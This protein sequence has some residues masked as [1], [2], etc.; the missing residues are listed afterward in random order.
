VPITCLLI[1]DRPARRPAKLVRAFLP[2]SPIS[3]R[4]SSGRH[5]ATA[6]RVIG[7]P[8]VRRPSAASQCCSLAPSVR[9]NVFAG[10]FGSKSAAVH[11][12]P[13]AAGCRVCLCPLSSRE[14]SSVAGPSLPSALAP[15]QRAG[16]PPCH[17]VLEQRVCSS[18]EVLAG[19]SPPP[20]AGDRVGVRCCDPVA[21]QPGTLRPLLSCERRSAA[22]AARRLHCAR[23]STRETDVPGAW[24]LSLLA[25]PPCSSLCC[26]AAYRFAPWS[27]ALAAGGPVLLWLARP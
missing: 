2:H 10:M 1:A 21:G 19:A 17:C 23:R 14:P 7:L 4:H 8:E 24:S 27:V 16:L 9:A 3:L 11:S 5:R 6:E 13:G 22:I 18:A 26:G 25:Q 15:C 12:A 20:L